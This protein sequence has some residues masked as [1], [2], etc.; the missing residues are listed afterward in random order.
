MKKLIGLIAIISMLALSA[1]APSGPSDPLPVL[2][3][4]MDLRYPPFETVDNNGT[5]SG[6]SVDIAKELGL[7]LGREVEIVDI[8]FGNLIT[9]L[10]L[11]EIDV[12]IA[13][14]TINDAR[15]EVIDFSNPYVYFPQVAIVNKAFLEANNYTTI[16]EVLDHDQVV[17]AGQKGTIFLSLPTS[18]AKN[19]GPVIETD[20]VALAMTEVS[21]GAAQATVLSLLAAATNAKAFPDTTVLLLEPLAVNNIGMGVRKGETELLNQLNAFIAQMESGGV[22]NRLRAKYNPTIINDFGLTAGLDLL[23]TND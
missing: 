19:P 7:F 22:N 12:I 5:P 10:N 11:G 13:S 9:E 14:M 2:K 23:L 18:L 8:S 3:V 15:K 17:F 6:I 21:T 1:C 4:G 16:Q 20:N